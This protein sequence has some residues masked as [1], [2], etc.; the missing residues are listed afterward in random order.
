M[1]NIGIIFN[2]AKP[3]AVKLARELLIWLEKE[4][5]VNV[6]FIKDYA[7]I[8][9]VPEKG[10][11]EVEL[12]EK[13]QCI[14]CLGGDGTILNAAK[15][16]AAAST[17]VA[18]VNLGE[19]GFLTAIEP[20]AEHLYQSIES[21][22]NGNF[23]LD[24]RMMLGAAVYR[25]GELIEECF[26]L[27]EVVITKGG[28]SRMIKL[29]TSIGEEFVGNYPADGLIIS[30]PT[31]STAYTLSAG[32]PIVSPQVEVIVL[33]PIC[34]HTLIARPIVFSPDEKVRTI[35]KTDCPDV[36]LTVD[37][38]YGVSLEQGDEIVVYKSRYKTS[39][40]RINGPSFYETIRT[41]LRKGGE[42]E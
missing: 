5:G 26:A 23:K 16:A 35:L 15:V 9:D 10:I 4:K 6:F 12:G 21:I 11:P 7:E 36:M 28:F 17:P 31:G 42:D 20:K 1:K 22:L 33:T 39:L 14:I 30:S 3:D 29:E 27:N 41:K 2:A 25:D 32:G 38:Q 18:G 13:S 40:I 8:L 19:V 37:G 24:P 34:P